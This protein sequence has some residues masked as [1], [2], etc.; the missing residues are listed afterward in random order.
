MGVEVDFNRLAGVAA[1]GTPEEIV[2]ELSNQFGGNKASLEEVQRNRF[3]KVAIERDLG[4]S[5]ADVK[6][7]AL[8]PGAVPEAQTT[9]E[10]MKSH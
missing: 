3:L 10:K 9:Q 2:K 8:G 6:K 5:I 4:L 7:L 1:T